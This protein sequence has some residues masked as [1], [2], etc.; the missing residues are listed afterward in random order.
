[1]PDN[2]RPPAAGAAG[3]TPRPWRFESYGDHEEWGDVFAADGTYL[4]ACSEGV[5]KH[6]VAAVNAYT[7]PAAGGTLE[8]R[9]DGFGRERQDLYLGNLFAGSIMQANRGKWD[10]GQKEWRGW[11]MSDEEG[12]ETGWFPTS[13]EARASVESAFH[14]ALQVQQGGE[15]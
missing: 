15:E 13:D 1:M 6:I 10:T 9:T 3:S 4:L 2:T 11:F 12:S 8:W 5:A 14:R 7:A